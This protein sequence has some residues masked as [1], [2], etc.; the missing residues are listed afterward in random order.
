MTGITIPPGASQADIDALKAKQQQ[1]ADRLA[2]V[3]AIGNEFKTFRDNATQFVG[4]APMTVAALLAGFPASA[5]N[6][7]RYARVTD[8]WGSVRT[9]MICESDGSSFYWR[10]Q[11]TDY[12]VN[13][14]ATGGAQT[15][16]PL[17]TAPIQVLTGT[18]LGTV[19]MT[20]SATN[21]WPGATFTIINKGVLGLFGVSLTGLVGNALPIVGGG[22]RTV[23]YTGAGWQAA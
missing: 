18:L 9:V 6:V 16:M 4:T 5:T 15:L 13:N 12:A 21:A 1:D 17:V 11:R 19:T 14:A 20:P 7:G 22:Q 10:P 23:T 3:E 8:L 2:A